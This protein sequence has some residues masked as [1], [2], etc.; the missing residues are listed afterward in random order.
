MSTERESAFLLLVLQSGI[1]LLTAIGPLVLALGGSRGNALLG[2]LAIALSV[3]E[4]VLAIL[5]QRGSRRATSWLA[6]YQALCLWGAGL[7]LGA[8][9]GADNHFAPLVTNLALPTLLLVLLMRLRERS[10]VDLGPPAGG[11]LEGE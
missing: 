4:L 8:H 2:V 1:G 3:V 7:A 11:R 10:S 5:F 9:L 6:G